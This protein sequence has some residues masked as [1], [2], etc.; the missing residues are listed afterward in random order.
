MEESLQWKPKPIKSSHL[1]N[2]GNTT[3]Q[4]FW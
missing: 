4:S 3:V 2:K 1:E